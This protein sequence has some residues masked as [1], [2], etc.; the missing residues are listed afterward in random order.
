MTVSKFKSQILEE[1]YHLQ[2]CELA[3]GLLYQQ[4]SVCYENEKWFWEEAIA[5]EVNHAR[6][7]GQMISLVSGNTQNYLPGRY[8]VDS[9]KTFLDGI[10]DKIDQIKSNKLNRQEILQMVLDY[11]NAPIESRPFEVVMTSEASFKVLASKLADDIKAHRQRISSYILSKQEQAA[12]PDLSGLSPP[13]SRLERPPST[14]SG[15][16]I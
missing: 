13:G 9:L 15:Q 6:A 1:L 7:A 8:R 10:Y 3:L 14:R 12:R 4:L 5:D 16:S 2:N 11:E